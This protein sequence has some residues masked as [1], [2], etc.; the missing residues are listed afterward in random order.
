[1]HHGHAHWATPDQHLLAHRF[2]QTA[3]GVLRRVV[4]PL[5]GGGHQS[6]HRGH[7]DE[8]TV[9]GGDQVRQELLGA[10]HHSPEVHSDDP[11]QVLVAEVCDL[12][13]ECD[14][15]VVDHQ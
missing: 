12:S 4:G 10:V 8:V 15:G 5:S 6:E 14:P 7:V 3:Y 1:M 11:V 13:G 2:G 9:T